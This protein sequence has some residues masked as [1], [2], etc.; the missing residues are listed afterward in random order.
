[1][2]PRR[3][4]EDHKITDFFG[5]DVFSETVMKNYL[6]KDA[7]DELTAV[8]KEGGVLHRSLADK[9]APAM[10]RWAVEKG[11]THYTHW[12][13]PL[14]GTTAEKHDSFISF[15]AEN[16]PIMEFSGK[17]L[18]KGEADASSFPSG[19]IRATFEARGYTVWDC[20]SP[21]FIKRNEGG[22]AV[23]YI[24]TAFCAYTGHSLDNK[25]PLLRSMEALNREGI[26]LLGHL[27][28]KVKKIITNVGAEQEYFLISKNHFMMR[29]DLKY[30]GR[31]LFGAPPAKGQEKNDQYYGVIRD[32]VSAFMADLNIELWKLGVTAKTEHNEVAPAQHEI[33]P[34]FASANIATDQNQ[35]M[36]EVMKKVAEKND[37]A[38]LLHEKPFKGLNGSGKHNN[39]SLSTD[40]G[41][42]LLEPGLSPSENIKFLLFLTA[43]IAGVDEYAEFLRMSTASAGND[44]R[45]G[46]HEA[47]P[48]AISIFIG[49]MLEEVINSV[50]AGTKGIATVKEYIKVGVSSFPKLKKD[51]SDRNRTSPFAFTGNK[52][53]FRMLGS[54]A[55]LA[56]PNIVLNT[57]TAEMLKRMSDEIEARKDKEPIDNIVSEIIVKNIKN[58]KRILFNGNNYS[59]EW[60][61]EAARRN[62]PN[63]SNSVDAYECLI[64]KKV[65]DLC[66]AHSVLSEAELLSRYEINLADYSK[67]VNIEALAARSLAKKQIFPAVL[68]YEGK[69]AEYAKS[70]RDVGIDASTH[71]QSV[72]KINVLAAKM[73]EQIDKLD[74]AIAKAN[75]CADRKAKAVICRD[76]VRTAMDELRS[77]ADELEVMIEKKEW[78]FPSYGDLL[79]YD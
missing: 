53:E 58:H 70:L 23:L 56:T 12:F 31:T 2:I 67:T 38:I 43:I 66:A 7:F 65:I 60:R 11:A 1:M 68:R 69:L 15:D 73:N 27:G 45:L 62:L 47:P 48:T 59:D 6:E 79:F 5:V 40:D 52:F 37:L 44:C 77:T 72:S 51:N 63:V 35:L 8:I 39:W 28:E 61:K 54:S 64:S 76:M 34:I 50:E 74:N 17:N 21:A 9:V 26:R 41:T 36:M 71:I 19:G 33:V 55:S 14:T 25:T 18:T 16:K 3:I 30:A 24:P 32:R 78:P 13:Q 29:D 46:S 49:D 57:I 20:S 4:T 75:A 42:N 10:M 22:A